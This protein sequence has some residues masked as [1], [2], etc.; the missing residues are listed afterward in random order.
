MTSTI[1]L[2][3]VLGL[4]HASRAANWNR[5]LEKRFSDAR[6]TFFDAGL[7]AC[8]STSDSSQFIV[9][10]NSQQYGGGEHCYKM[11]EI[12]YNGKT[13]QAQIVDECPDCPYAA[14]DFSTAL[15]DH[16]AS[17]DLG[18]IYGSWVF[19]DAAKPTTTTTKKTTT[20]TKEHTTAT[21]FTPTQAI[22]TT[23]SSSID[24]PSS[25]FFDTTSSSSQAVDV[26]ATVTTTSSGTASATSST[27]S[28]AVPS[29][30]PSTPTIAGALGTQGQPSRGT[31]HRI[32]V[33]W[34]VIGVM[35][36]AS[37]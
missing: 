25:S 13:A 31:T 20:T 11:I 23:S 1:L 14:L 28:I 21:R 32:E 19:A 15:F 3:L 4:V 6:F 33:L 24:R 9:A 26:D 18:V 37:Q 34:L 27:T 5:T 35:V 29:T 7:G 36:I 16:F 12:T 17:E 30:L 22:T 2:L 10:L 8:G